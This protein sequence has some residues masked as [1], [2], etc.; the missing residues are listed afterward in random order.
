MTE[1]AFKNAVAFRVTNDLGRWQV[2]VRGEVR[3]VAGVVVTTGPDGKVRPEV[4]EMAKRNVVE[5][6]LRSLYE[7]RV[8]LFCKAI[9][10]LHRCEPFS[11]GY[12]E[13]VEELL[14][15]AKRQPPAWAQEEVET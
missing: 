4:M 14:Q 2:H 10:R 1:D 5:C 12:H 15:L 13:M 11:I 6:L 7:D 3:L 9:E 8:A